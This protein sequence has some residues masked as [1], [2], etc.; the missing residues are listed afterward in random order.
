VYVQKNSVLHSYYGIVSGH[1]GPADPFGDA[2][3]VRTPALAHFEHTLWNGNTLDSFV[4]PPA[5]VFE[6]VAPAAGAPLYVAPSADP[7][8]YHLAPGSAA[9]DG[10]V[11]STTHRD[12]DGRRRG[13][14]GAS[15]VGAY[16]WGASLDPPAPERMIASVFADGTL[17]AV[18]PAT[19]ATDALGS[20]PRDLVG[21]SA[22]RGR[23]F[24]LWG[25]EQLIE[26][27]PATGAAIGTTQPSIGV[28]DEGDFAIRADGSALAVRRNAASDQLWSFKVSG[29][30]NTTLVQPNLADVLD[31]LTFAPGGALGLTQ[32][33][34]LVAV[35]TTNGALSTIGS[36]GLT[37]PGTAALARSVTGTVYATVGDSLYSVDPVTAAPR[38]IGTLADGPF[39]SG[40]VVG[41][42][43]VPEPS[44]AAEALAALGLL[45]AVRGRKTAHAS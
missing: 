10:A 43:F 8:D 35:D 18:D 19:A 1:A 37:M 5:A 7:A 25:V 14:G 6:D 17:L 45:I 4:E 24:G 28:G 32:S 29:A 22:W 27:D 33:G 40:G 20:G 12:L 11:G 26:L 21:L 36:T 31:G 41:L 42:A 34:V 23:L 9:I 13:V 44:A 15:D 30:P 16:E 3:I 39:A 2:V 38:L